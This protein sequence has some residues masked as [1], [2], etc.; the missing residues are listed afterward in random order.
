MSKKLL[1]ALIA[2]ALAAGISVI[3]TTAS[4]F[5]PGPL[6]KNTKLSIIQGVG[7][8][9]GDAQHAHPCDTGSCFS[10]LNG[11]ITTWT[12]FGPGTDGGFIIGVDQAPG[13]QTTYPAGSDPGQLTSAWSF[14]GNEGSNATA[15]FS[16][17]NSDGI[18]TSVTTTAGANQ[19]WNSS[20]S[21]TVDC[22]NKTYLGSWHVNWNGIAIPMGSALGCKARDADQSGCI[23]VTVWTLSDNPA[24][25]GS[26]YELR[27]SWVVPDGDPSGFANVH[28]S[29]ILRG[30]V[31]SI[32]PTC[33]NAA[34][35]TYLCTSNDAC[36]VPLCNGDTGVCS[37]T[38]LNCDDGN[39]C[40]QDTCNSFG[41]I[42]INYADGSA[43][44]DNNS[45]TLSDHCMSGT[46]VGTTKTCNAPDACVVAACNK[47]TGNCEQTPRI[48][49]SSACITGTCDPAI[50]CVFTGNPLCVNSGNNNFTMID[51]NNGL[52][53]GTNDVHFT[54]DRTTKTAVAVSGQVSNATISSPC[55]F[56]GST[57]TA[58]DVAVYGP[59]TYTVYA[60]CSAGSPGCGIGTPITFTVGQGELGGHMLFN[61]TT[62]KD[63]DVVDIWTPHAAFGKS[64]MQTGAGGCGVGDPAKVWDLMSKDWDGDGVNGKGMVDG[65]FKNFN[66]NFNLMETPNIGPPTKPELVFPAD[67]QTGLPSTVEFIWKRSTDPD[68]DPITYLFTS[69]TD[70]TFTD[71]SCAPMTVASRNS[72]G[73][74]Y[75]GGAGLL[76][77]GMTF[78]GGLKG[79]RM[80]VLLFIIVVLLSGGALISCSNSNNSKLQGK[81]LDIGEKSFT[82]SGLSSRT[83]Y[84]WKV[85]AGDGKADPVESN[86]NSFTTQ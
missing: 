17:T 55:P 2:I 58:H 60:G 73:M 78:F 44:S 24:K 82:V 13:N 74:F 61:W 51:P 21:G 67:K 18:V 5:V 42:H 31:T 26:T 25:I 53:G 27:H 49:D 65:P 20:C 56:F 50:G 35:Q 70:S 63:I 32:T 11:S 23:G 3:S 69:C 30:V 39:P 38:T 6:P 16:A 7:S 64:P 4:A 66:A 34:T 72:K 85:S 36:T 80:I 14:F 37:S 81:F 8:V 19:F 71:A 9:T 12:D 79:R 62:N 59:G 48:C 54:W 1:T 76:M 47:T 57:W 43:C 41:C 29:V 15:A 46:C 84:Y 86:V 83:T 77:I 28:Y 45:C 40:T 33:Y 52:V 75:A 22:L 10:M 68:P